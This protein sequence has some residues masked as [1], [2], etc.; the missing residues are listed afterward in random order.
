MLIIFIIL[1]KKKWALRLISP[2]HLENRMKGIL[3]L[4]QLR[5]IFNFYKTRK[6]DPLKNPLLH[7]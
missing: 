5:G 1:N 6:E 4:A 7:F 2:K 3:F